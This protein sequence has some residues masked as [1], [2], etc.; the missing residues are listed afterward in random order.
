VVR[1]IP[2]QPMSS[3]RSSPQRGDPIAVYV[4]G[5]MPGRGLEPAIRALALAPALRLRLV[6]PGSDAY[7]ARLRRCAEDAGVSERVVLAPPVPPTRVLDAIA[8]ATLGVMLIE[9]ICRS[10]ELTVPN[11]LFEYAAAGLPI[12]SSDLPVIGPLVTAEQ[13]GE[14]VPPDDIELIA[15]AMERLGDLTASREVRER[16][17]SFARRVTWQQEQVVLEQIYTQGGV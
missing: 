4:G 13:L 8:D 17:R 12:L 5:L 9:P 7:C 11:K 1:N 15:R 6:G 14:V 3:S 2:V 16:V 10:Y